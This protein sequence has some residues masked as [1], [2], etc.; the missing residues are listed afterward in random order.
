MT[1]FLKLLNTLGN[2]H[3]TFN[4]CIKAVKA[5]AISWRRH[6]PYEI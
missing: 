5:L 3:L 2:K 6:V 4:I 1:L